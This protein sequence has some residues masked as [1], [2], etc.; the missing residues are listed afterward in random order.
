[1]QVGIKDEDQNALR[2]LWPTK[3]GIKQ[4]QYTRL[5]FSAKCSPSIAIFALHRTAADYC[6]TK[7]NIAQLLH[8]SFYVD[9]FV[10]S[11]KTTHEARVSTT[12]LKSSLRQGRF[13]LTKFVSNTNDAIYSTDRGVVST[14]ATVHP[15]LGVKWDTTDD[16]IFVQPTTKVTN[17]TSSNTPNSSLYSSKCFRHLRYPSAVCHKTQNSS[18]KPVEVWYL[19]GR[20]RAQWLCSDNWQMG[21]PM[22]TKPPGKAARLLGPQL[23]PS[24]IQLHVFCDASQDSMATCIYFWTACSSG[25]HATFLIGRTKVA[26]L[27]QERITK[28]ELQAALMD[29]RLCKFAI[30]EMRIKPHS[31]HFWT[32]STTVL[33]WIASPGKLKTYCANSWWNTYLKQGR[34]METHPWYTQPIRQ[35]YTGNWT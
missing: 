19:L 25:I 3:K 22:Q 31:T 30:D 16:T 32:D 33:S 34:T 23:S 17:T 8:K 28:L 29:A 18:A 13:N 12:Q 7:P 21:R 27:N 35:C 11:F 24:D 4:N 10:H 2:F 1:M 5:I 20:N 26:P 9:D 15:V 14:N 6:V